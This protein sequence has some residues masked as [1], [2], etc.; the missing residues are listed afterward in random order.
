MVFIFSF[1]M[2][3]L[4]SVFCLFSTNWKQIRLHSEQCKH[5]KEQPTTLSSFLNIYSS[6]GNRIVLLSPHYLIQYNRSRAYL[7]S[8]TPLFKYKESFTNC[9]PTVEPP[10]DRLSLIHNDI[11][12]T[13]NGCRYT[14]LKRA[15]PGQTPQYAF[16]NNDLVREPQSAALLYDV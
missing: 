10:S 16:C 15:W 9:C 13:L 7:W 6:H 2:Y 14:A 5:L 1:T 11:P 12:G 8:V 4:L 3:N